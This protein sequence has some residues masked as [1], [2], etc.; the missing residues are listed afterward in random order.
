MFKDSVFVQMRAYRCLQE[1]ELL[2]THAADIIL[3]D[4]AH[5]SFKL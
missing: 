3:V 2:H 4:V 1:N 5:M